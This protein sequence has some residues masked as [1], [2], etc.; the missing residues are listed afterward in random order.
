[1]V[2]AVRKEAKGTK[3]NESKVGG[4]A[5]TMARMGVNL[6]VIFDKNLTLL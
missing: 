3:E 2:W 5:R 4:G 1:M 6:R